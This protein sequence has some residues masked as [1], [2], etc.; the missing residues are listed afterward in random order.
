[1]LSWF[2]TYPVDALCLALIAAGLFGLRGTGKALQRQAA[3][4]AELSAE[5]GRPS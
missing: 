3:R 2:A 1:V 4:R 5:L